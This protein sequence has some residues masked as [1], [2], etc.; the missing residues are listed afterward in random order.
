M[1][2]LNV[3][4]FVGSNR[5]AFLLQTSWFQF[6]CQNFINPKM[7]IWYLTIFREFKLNNC[8][9]SKD[10]L[11]CS[12]WTSYVNSWWLVA[13]SVIETISILSP[14]WTI[15][16]CTSSL[17]LETLQSLL[18]QIVVVFASLFSIWAYHFYFAEQDRQKMNHLF[19][20]VEDEKNGNLLMN[21]KLLMVL[22]LKTSNHIRKLQNFFFWQELLIHS[23]QWSSL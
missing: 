4:E 2:R 15:Q 5:N 7:L 11:L 18:P 19:S 9:I 8:I 22:T 17:I 23:W 14:S 12:S 10:F 6:G 1:V 20:F 16:L 13:R 21:L 3:F